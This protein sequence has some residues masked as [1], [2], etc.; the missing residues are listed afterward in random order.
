MW[1]TATAR[2]VT[3]SG[4]GHAPAGVC[5]CVCEGRGQAVSVWH[6]CHAVLLEIVIAAVAAAAACAPVACAARA[7][8]HTKFD[9]YLSAA[10]K[11]GPAYPLPPS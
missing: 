2:A 8:L 9:F 7:L 10:S 11:G 1:R 6:E 3:K 4:L 5:G